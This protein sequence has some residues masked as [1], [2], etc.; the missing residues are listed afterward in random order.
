[1]YAFDGDFYV[2]ICAQ[3][4]PDIK[5]NREDQQTKPTIRQR[6]PQHNDQPL[7]DWALSALFWL[8]ENPPPFEGLG[9]RRMISKY[10]PPT[11]YV[12]YE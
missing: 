4:L 8:M 3:R 9:L 12:R 6:E 5:L 11:K 7:A 2:V 10:R 1:L